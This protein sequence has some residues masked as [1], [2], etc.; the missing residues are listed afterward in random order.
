VAGPIAPSILINPTFST[1][2][3]VDTVAYAS[4][5]STLVNAIFIGVTETAALPLNN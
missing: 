1:A 3:V 4:Q 2:N 5:S